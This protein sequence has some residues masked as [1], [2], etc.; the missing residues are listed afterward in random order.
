MKIKH[1]G[2]P[3]DVLFSGGSPR[4]KIK[5][6]YVRVIFTESSGIFFFMLKL[7]DLA[8]VRQKHIITLPFFG[9]KIPDW[10]WAELEN[11]RFD[12]CQ[13]SRV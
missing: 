10:P 9:T 12:P 8:L 5:V 7:L 2:D 13:N 4:K 1:L 11:Y 3:P 6:Q